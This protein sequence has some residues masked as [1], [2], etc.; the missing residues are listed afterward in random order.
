MSKEKLLP[1]E[2]ALSWKK[3]ERLPMNFFYQTNRQGNSAVCLSKEKYSKSFSNFFVQ[4]CLRLQCKNV[5][6]F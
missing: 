5:F 2:C 6:G 3:I 4:T 1:N